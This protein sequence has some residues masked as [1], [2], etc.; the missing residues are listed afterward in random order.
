[1]IIHSAGNQA[2][3]LVH[4]RQVLSVATKLHFQ[5]SPLHLFHT[6]RMLQMNT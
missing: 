1:M 6:I 3:G 2:Q 5:A 4:A